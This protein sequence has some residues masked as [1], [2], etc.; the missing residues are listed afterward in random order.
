MHAYNHP[1]VFPRSK[2]HHESYP[3]SQATDY[4]L[5]ATS[6]HTLLDCTKFRLQTVVCSHT[7]H[8]HSKALTSRPPY[9]STTGSIPQLASPLASTV[10]SQQAC[11]QQTCEDIRS[12]LSISHAVYQ[13]QPTP[14][15]SAQRTARICPLY[16]PVVGSFIQRLQAS[17]ASLAFAHQPTMT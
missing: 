3:S 12:S 1:T 14:V 10:L 8:A 15:L 13:P 9:R 6:R 4:M 5:S 16:E 17:P 7:Y 11:S 2:L